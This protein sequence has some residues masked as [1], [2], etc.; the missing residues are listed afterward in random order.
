MAARLRLRCV[1]EV[2]GAADANRG[3]AY[4]SPR[5]NHAPAAAPSACVMTC[6]K[7]LARAGAELE[8]AIVARASGASSAR[9]ETL[10]SR[11]K[12]ALKVRVLCMQ[13]VFF[14]MHVVALAELM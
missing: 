11:C 10:P 1:N 14:A 3:M 5:A 2:L 8:S 13:E 4:A 7:L 9:S 6:I 12:Q